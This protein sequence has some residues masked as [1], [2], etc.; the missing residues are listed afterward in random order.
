MEKQALRLYL[1]FMQ[2][3]LVRVTA[4]NPLAF[5]VNECED[6]HGFRSRLLDLL[7]LPVPDNLSD[8]I[9]KALARVSPERNL[10]ALLEEYKGRC[11]EAER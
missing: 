4:R 6:I 3:T 5:A 1:Q 10:A 9:A 2:N 11:A 7:H 8:A